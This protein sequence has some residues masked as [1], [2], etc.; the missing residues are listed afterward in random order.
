MNC[1]TALLTAADRMD[2][3]MSKSWCAPG[4]SA[5]MT[6]RLDTAYPLHEGAHVRRRYQHV[7]LAVHHEHGWHV[8]ARCRRRVTPAALIWLA[9]E[10]GTVVPAP[11][12][13]LT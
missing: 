13:Q 9:V 3:N 8:A 2:S 5:Q 1:S 11:D 6:G 7:L 4:S 12:V 10:L